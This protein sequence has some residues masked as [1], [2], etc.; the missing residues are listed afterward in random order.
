MSQFSFVRRS[1]TSSR[2]ASVLAFSGALVFAAACS[3]DPATAPTAA[4]PG[5]RSSDVVILIV[6]R[7]VQVCKDVSSPAGTYTYNVSR[8]GTALASDVF[9]GV[10][11]N[12]N[13]SGTTTLT[14]GTCKDVYVRTQ[15]PVGT[16]DPGVLVTIA[17]QPLAGTTISNMTFV[18]IDNA[19]DPTACLVV[20]S[21]GLFWSVAT[22]TATVYLNAFHSDI[23]RYFSIPVVINRGCTYTQGWYKNQGVGSLPAGN[24]F[25]SGQTYLQVLDTPPKGGNVYYQLAHQYIAARLNRNSASGTAAVDAALAG[26]LVYFGI[27]TPSATVPAGYTSAQLLAWASTLDSYNNGFT[28]PGHCG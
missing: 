1:A 8:T 9:L 4:I 27:A 20:C 13:N 28:G 22:G 25:K 15:G 6:P 19:P 23:V 26:A 21:N 5:A 16:T 14:P 7:T 24:F 17:E 18:G 12:V 3:S 2:V 10:T 11:G